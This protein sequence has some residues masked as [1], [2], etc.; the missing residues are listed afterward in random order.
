MAGGGAGFLTAPRIEPARPRRVARE[1][2]LAHDRPVSRSRGHAGGRALRSGASP[3]R[4]PAGG[5]GAVVCAGVGVVSVLGACG[6][7][8]PSRA[9]VSTTGASLP[10]LAAPRR[11]P[12]ALSDLIVPLPP[13][14]LRACAVAVGG[15]HACVLALDDEVRCWGSNEHHQLGG[16]TPAG[17]GIPVAVPGLRE[18]VELDA[19]MVHTCARTRG[20]E[21]L[22][23]GGGDLG[24]IGD[25]S[26]LR[27]AAPTRAAVADARS[28]DASSS[29][30]CARLSS[31]QTRCWGYLPSPVD[32]SS[33][34]PLVFPA[35]L[36]IPTAEPLRAVIDLGSR[37]AVLLPDGAVHRWGMVVQS[38][39]ETPPLEGLT[40]VE[41]LG[42]A[43]DLV[44]GQSFMCAALADGAWC[45]GTGRHHFF[46]GTSDAPD[47]PVRIEGTA[48]G[49]LLAAGDGFL[50]AAAA[51]ETRCAGWGQLVDAEGGIWPLTGTATRVGALDG[52]EAIDA[53]SNTVCILAAGAVR[54]VGWRSGLE[55]TPPPS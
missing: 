8:A 37:A 17:P 13:A 45:W 21:V 55:G 53:G 2:D 19:G 18:V 44:A 3:S 15:A 47:V 9:P 12:A 35:E 6:A 25:G 54:C 29:A 30:T 36:G 52:A 27:R 41:P 5:W 39:L 38:G 23:W 46:G 28:I 1:A 33:S 11:D 7:P 48:G 42:T 16:A 50:C 31:G 34:A 43:S 24:E 22:C 14:G 32:G 4:S 20:G 10:A 49:A 40:R 51:G 26:L